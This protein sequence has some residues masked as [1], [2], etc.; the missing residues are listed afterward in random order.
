MSFEETIDVVG[1]VIDA[2]GVAAI[3][4]GALAATAGCLLR[5]RRA[6][7]FANVYGR[8]RQDLGRAV[9]LGLELLVAGDIVRTVAVDPTLESVGVVALL[10]A[11]RTFLSMT[12]I[13][14]LE[15]RL[16]WHRPA[17]SDQPARSTRAG[18]E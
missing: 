10:V 6:G 4:L 12:L 2:A 18:K 7:E 16:P 13:V 8:Y 15:G 17:T 14:E 1:R 5:W 9:L 11:V 3:A